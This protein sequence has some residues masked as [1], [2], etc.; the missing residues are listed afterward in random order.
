MFKQFLESFH[1]LTVDEIELIYS[2]VTKKQLLKNEFYI[3]EGNVCKDVAFI[4]KGIFRSFYLSAKGD[5]MTYCI[6]FPNNFITAYSS[7]ITGQKSIENLQAITDAELLVLSKDKIETMSETHPNIMKF[8][9]IIAEYQYIELEQRIF[10]LQ[11]N[12]AQERYLALINTHP[13]FVKHIPLQYL[14]SYL[15]ITQ[16]H[17][18]RIRNEITI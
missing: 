3:K 11:R 17:L 4:E 2:N 10:Q 12:N 9:K 6:T 7:F 14:A 18:S 16:R 13:E 1:V 5:E 15:G 8:L